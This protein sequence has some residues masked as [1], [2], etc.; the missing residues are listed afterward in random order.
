MS[1]VEQFAD[2]LV[3]LSVTELLDLKKVLKDKYNLEKNETIAPVAVKE[4]K[5]EV[6]EKTNFTITLNKVSEVTTDK[7]NI[8]RAIKEF[9]GLPLAEAKALH[10]AAPSIIKENISK[11]DCDVIVERMKTFNADITVS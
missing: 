5:E 2:Q 9:T 6:V 10:D 1:K 8:I 3:T 4:E 7:M 11:N